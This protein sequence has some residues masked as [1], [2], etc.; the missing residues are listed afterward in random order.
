MTE[1]SRKLEDLEDKITEYL[2]ENRDT[3]HFNSLKG[4]VIM[5]AI[6][7]CDDLDQELRSTLEKALELWRNSASFEEISDN[8]IERCRQNLN[9][10]I[11]EAGADSK[12][13]WLARLNYTSLHNTPEDD[14]TLLTLI[15]EYSTTNDLDIDE[16][17]KLLTD[18]FPDFNI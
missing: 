11:K 1:N 16:L 15:L 10:A 17:S 3:A 7:A 18:Q 13:A 5:L 6:N 4:V 12:D 2:S 14:D 8:L 9:K